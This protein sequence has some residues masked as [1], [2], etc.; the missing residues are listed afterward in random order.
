MLLGW[1]LCS[2]LHG[3][4][5][6]LD[7]VHLR[8]GHSCVRGVGVSDPVHVVVVF[9]VQHEPQLVTSFAVEAFAPVGPADLE[10]FGEGQRVERA[11]LAREFARDCPPRL[12]VRELGNDAEDGSVGRPSATASTTSWMM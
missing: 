8:L 3:L 11:P 10:P 9:G 6:F 2:L 12:V 7:L 1:L 4:A 5:Q